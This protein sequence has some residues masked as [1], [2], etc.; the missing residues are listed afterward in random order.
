MSLIPPSLRAGPRRPG[1]PGRRFSPFVGASGRGCEGSVLLFPRVRVSVC[2][3]VCGRHGQLSTGKGSG[4]YSA[5]RKHGP[6]AKREGGQTRPPGEGRLRRG[7]ET[8]RGEIGG[9]L[10]ILPDVGFRVGRPGAPNGWGLGGMPTFFPHLLWIHAAPNTHTHTPASLPPSLPPASPET[11]RRKANR[12]EG[13]G[14][15]VPGLGGERAR[16]WPPGRRRGGGRGEGEGEREGE[17]GNDDVKFEE[18]R[19]TIWGSGMVL[20]A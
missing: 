2:A 11:G 18:E 3:C 4:A 16:D 17:S 12:T 13:H 8:K 5:H 19:H 20:R 7:Q 14:R 15:G 10:S 6:T 9:E 1:F